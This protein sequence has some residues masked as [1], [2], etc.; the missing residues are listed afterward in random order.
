MKTM[1]DGPR[2]GEY[3]WPVITVMLVAFPLYEFRGEGSTLH[4]AFRVALSI[5]LFLSVIEIG[6]QLHGDLGDR[7]KVRDESTQNRQP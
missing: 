7:R 1:A 6:R 3:F 4:W 5:V 2:S